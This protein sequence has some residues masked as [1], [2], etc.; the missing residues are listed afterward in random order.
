MKKET[1]AKN[2]KQLEFRVNQD[3]TEDDTL[4]I[5]QIRIM[6]D[7][8]VK[9]VTVSA[10]TLALNAGETAML[11]ATV[12]PAFAPDLSVSYSSSQENVAK[13]DANTGVVTAM[14]GGTATITVTT[15]DGGLTDQCIV[16][17]T[18][19]T[20]PVESVS[21][22]ETTKDVLAGE[23]FVLTATILPAN[24]SN[25]SVSWSSSKESVATV[26][27]NGNVTG[28]AAGTATITVTTT[29]GTKTATCLVTVLPLS[30]ANSAIAAV[31][32][33]PVPYYTGALN[34]ETTFEGE[35]HT[36]IYDIAG[37]KVMENLQD[38][39]NGKVVLYPRLDTGMYL[40]KLTN[41]NKV[42]IT[43]LLVQ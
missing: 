38:A 11:F 22:S 13:V 24:A 37:N 43:K 9:A 5:D 30:V 4:Y 39:E 8:A 2:F 29:D 18:G 12:V 3:H 32:V 15:A 17:V 20:V 27:P 40:V 36:E 1:K 41:N 31:K 26:T 28:V 10:S 25:K 21:L 6:I 34:I 19:A 16:T 14:G 42:S 33:Y 35:V 7:T 23:S